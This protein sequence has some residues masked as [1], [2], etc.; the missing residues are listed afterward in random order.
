M[1]STQKLILEDDLFFEMRTDFNKVLKKQY[2]IWKKK[3]Q[4][5]LPSH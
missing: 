3:A 2:S 1:N 4:K 5:K